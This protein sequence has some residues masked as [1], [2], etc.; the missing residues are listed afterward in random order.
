MK[1]QTMY[2]ADINR[3]INGVIK[4]AQDDER[5]LEQELREYIITK[6]LRRHFSTFLNHYEASLEQPTDKIGVW[7]S[8]FFGSGKSHFLKILSYLFE[9]PVVAGKHA[10]DY[11]ADKFDDPMMFGRLESCVKV[12]TRAILFN[13]DSKSPLTKD[14]TAILRVFA[15]VFYEHLGFYGNDLKVAKLEQFIA[16]SGKTEEFRQA[17]ENVNGGTWEESRDS[18]AFF[19]DDVVEAMTTALG[20]SETA[21]RNWFNGE[22]EID[23]S[24]EQLVKEIKEYI[25]SQGKQFR[26]MF[27]IDEVGQYIGSDS[28][29]MLNLQTIVEEIGT[30]CDGRVWVMVTSQEAIDSITKISGNDFSKIQGRFNTRLSLSSSSVDEVIKKRILAK[31]VAAEG[32]LKLQYDKNQAVLR[33]LFSF[34]GAVLDLK[35][36]AGEGEFIDTYPFVPYQ[37]RLMQNVLAQIRKHGNS[38][39]HLSGG[40]RS[41]LSGFQEAAQAIQ[42]KD[43]YALIPFSLFYDTVHTFLESSIRRVIDRCQTAADN[44]DGIEPYDVSVLKLLYLIRYVDDVKANLDNIT[45]LMTD[46]IRA[47]KITM[48]QT[49]QQSLDRL[50]SQNY[51]SRAGD[52]YTFLT[53]DEQDIAR[54]I[55]NTP[56]NS[57]DVTLAIGDVI[58]NKLY[59]SKKFRYGKYDFAYDRQIDETPIGQPSGNIMLQFITVASEIYSTDDNV[60]QHKSGTNNAVMIVLSD[61]MPYFEELEFAMKIRNYVKGKNVAQLPEA[62]QTIIRSRTSEASAHEKEAEKLITQA[63]SDSRIYVAGERLNLRISSVKDRIEQ[64]L[65]TLIESV[66]TKLEY[67]RKNYDSDAEL[68][69]ILSGANKQMS[70]GDIGTPNADAVKEMNEYLVRQKER[71][72]PTSMGDIQ[73]RFSAIPYGWREIDIA[74]VAAEMI[75]DGKITLKYAGNVIAASDKKLPDYLR[76][77]TEIDKAIISFRVAPPVALIKKSRDFLGEYYNCGLG[78]IPDTENELITYIIDKFTDQRNNLNDLLSKQYANHNYPGKAIVEQGVRLCNDLLMHKNDSIA[79]LEQAVKMQDDFLDNAEDI[80]DVLT[81]FRVQQQIFD[82]AQEKLDAVSAEKEY[83]SAEQAALS[84]L[85]KMKE[86]LTSAKPYRRISE[87]PELTQSIQEV[88]NRL[89]NDKREEVYAEIHAAM[90]EIHQTAAIEQTDI[91]RRADAELEDKKSSAEQSDKLTALDAMKIQIANIRQRYL[92]KLVTV[93]P[94]VDTVTMNRSTVCHTMKLQ[95]E[96]DIDAYLAEIKKTL[97]EKLEGHDVLHII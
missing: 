85:S 44:M 41:M 28:D 37:F 17:F 6:E 43:E 40:E 10:V 14:K 13:I 51:V 77:K 32:V 31:T 91:V 82:K 88:Y 34:N 67:I 70:F 80:A 3:D 53:D 64:A 57:A 78:A 59:A 76:R 39:K 36:Y 58:F 18:F 84:T 15:K 25:D 62:I 42:D 11:F 93:E 75:A 9:N 46:D 92:Q 19:E 30:K 97:M 4:V 55:R 87:L 86:I 60:F 48:R 1:L 56:V 29:L 94:S 65:S 81:F 66:Y 33:N 74:A 38:G 23:L 45:V 2:K 12:P 83:F 27:M 22:E 89:L 21:A 24:I 79:L 63:I 95:S 49:I 54:D 68:L 8:G 69:E 35:G 7:I 47:D 90:G 20:I 16:K 61:T 72:L 96:A 26:L 52:T 5:S 73:R 71:A 50:V